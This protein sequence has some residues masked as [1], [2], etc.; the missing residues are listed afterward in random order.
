MGDHMV[1][2]IPI[3]LV[4]GVT[5]PEVLGRLRPAVPTL[6]M[7]MTF[8]NSLG[9]SLAGLRRAIRKPQALFLTLLMVH[10]IVPLVAFA[11]AGLLFGFNSQ[12]VVGVVL[13]YVVPI[14]SSTVMWV[15]MCEGD[16]LLMLATLLVSTTIVPFS[17]P[18]SLQI[19]VGATVEVDSFGLM[20]DMAYMVALPALVAT[21]INEKSHGR[22]AREVMPRLSPI[23]RIL[24]PI[25]VCANSTGIAD[26]LRHLT[27]RL[28]GIAVFIGVFAVAG[29]ALGIVLG[30][31]ARQPYE[32]IA[33]MTF[34]CGVRNISAGAV[35]ASTYFS[36]EALFPAVIGTLFQQT[37]AAAFAHVLIKRKTEWDVSPASKQE[38]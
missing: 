4:F 15:S 13:E 11:S 24:L 26:Q 23:S 38:G 25:I 7:I 34:G 31:I 6:F 21:F 2:V 19:L 10:V 22:A 1:V 17:I 36:A 35:L 20:R 14:G 37:L 12:T 3:C 18:A 16:V 28:V 32:R 8:Q 29:Y 30:R 9:N 33:V 27:P 5:F